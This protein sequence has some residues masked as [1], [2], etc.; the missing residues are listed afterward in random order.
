[1]KILRFLVFLLGCAIASAQT[2]IVTQTPVVSGTGTPVIGGGSGTPVVSGTGTPIASGGTPV[3]GAPAPPQGN[4]PGGYITWATA[5]GF[6]T[7]T[8]GTNYWLQI[9]LTTLATSPPG[10]TYSVLAAG[11][12][13]SFSTMSSTSVPAGS[14][15]T[16]TVYDGATATALTCTQAPLSSQRCSDYTHQVSVN[17]GDKLYIVFQCT[18]TCGASSMGTTIAIVGIVPHVATTAPADKKGRRDAFK[19]GNF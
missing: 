14:S 6:Q 8:A 4:A 1:V 7:M 5:S 9:A 2:P 16:A 10:M 17:Q 15:I 19:K 12:L 13:T 3:I 18:G 11:S